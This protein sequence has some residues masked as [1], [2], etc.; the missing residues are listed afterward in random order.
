MK[1]RHLLAQKFELFCR[2]IQLKRQQIAKNERMRLQVDLEFHQNEI[3]RLNEKC[4]ME[5]FSSRMRGGKPYAAEQKIRDFK[6]LLFNS[7]KAHQQT[8]TSIKFDP[9]KLI[10]K[11]IANL[12]IQS[13]KYD[14]PRKRI[15]KNA[16]R[17][18]KSRDIYEFYRLLKVHKTF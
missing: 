2:D 16:I 6:K 10:R 4:N 5:M 11:V 17:S 9:K 14:Y 8:S 1:N 13:Q 3:K 7:K 12:N 18:E 15:E